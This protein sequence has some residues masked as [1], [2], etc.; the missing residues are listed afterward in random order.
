MYLSRVSH[1]KEKFLKPFSWALSIIMAQLKKCDCSAPAI[2]PPI[3]RFV[4]A[5]KLY[6]SQVNVMVNPKGA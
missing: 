6:G 1:S 5:F 4:T 2:L 3:S